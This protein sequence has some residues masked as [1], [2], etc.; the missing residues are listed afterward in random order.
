MIYI[1]SV[2]VLAGIE[3]IF[4]IVAGMELCLGFVL[5]ALIFYYCW[6]ILAQSQ[7][8]FCLSAHSTNEESGTQQTWG[9]IEGTAE[10]HRP[11]GYSTP[12]VMELCFLGM[13]E[14]LPA[15]MKLWINPLFCFASLH[16][17][18]FPFKP[19]VSTHEFSEFSDSGGGFIISG[20]V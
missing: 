5:E 16:R 3:S 18:C 2:L 19:F 9:D 4:F 1:L 15:C 17:L 12:H 14:H 13:A 11:K 10:P 6:A 8:P 20:K 7:G